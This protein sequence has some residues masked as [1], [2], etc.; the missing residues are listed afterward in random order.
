MKRTIST[1]LATVMLFG[2]TGMSSA[3]AIQTSP[4]QRVMQP[5]PNARSI[6]FAFVFSIINFCRCNNINRGQSVLFV[7]KWRR[8]D[9]LISIN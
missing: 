2:F 7:A 4:Q 6:D 9:I 3:L 8:C 1:V 5:A